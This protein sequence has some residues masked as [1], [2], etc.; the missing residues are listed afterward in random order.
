[1]R[2]CAA[3]NSFAWL[4]N[5]GNRAIQLDP[6]RVVREVKYHP[7][8]YLAHLYA[9]SGEREKASQLLAEA[10]QREERLGVVWAYGYALIQLGFGDNER[11]IDWLE[12]SYQA[13][14]TG[15]IPY[16]QFDPLLNPL[17][18]DPRFEALADKIVPSASK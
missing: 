17:R 18:G 2:S 3:R 15:I 7:V 10:K 14:E 12:R 13:K 8:V 5:R 11:A 1:M 6:K 4:K 16:I 9:V